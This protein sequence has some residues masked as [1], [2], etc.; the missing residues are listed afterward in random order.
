MGRQGRALVI[1][2]D[3]FH[4]GAENGMFGHP[5]R[6]AFA[7]VTPNRLLLY[8]DTYSRMVTRNGPFPKIHENKRVAMEIACFSHRE[9]DKCSVNPGQCA[10]RTTGCRVSPCKVRLGNFEDMKKRGME[11]GSLS[12]ISVSECRIPHIETSFLWL[13]HVEISRNHS[14]SFRV[15]WPMRSDKPKSFTWAPQGQIGL[16]MDIDDNQF[17]SIR[18]YGHNVYV[19]GLYIPT[20]QYSSLC[21]SAVFFNPRR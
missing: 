7:L 10:C 11:E 9:I 12:R 1:V 3:Q 19:R 16:N 13:A 20:G 6:T 15:V 5:T 14:M 21:V 2:A 8:E 18:P 17:A 4:N